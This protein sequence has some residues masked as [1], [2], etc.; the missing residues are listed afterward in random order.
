MQGTPDLAERY[1]EIHRVLAN[2]RRLLILWTLADRELS[3]SEIA[4]AIGASLQS[5]SQHL[6]LLRE[7][8]MVCSRRVGQI[9]YYRLHQPANLPDPPWPILSPDGV[10][11]A[12]SGTILR[13]E[14]DSNDG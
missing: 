8:S 12:R 2:R 5:T 11:A 9:V 7:H 3:V 14:E 6:R 1:A 13:T 4:I 10:E